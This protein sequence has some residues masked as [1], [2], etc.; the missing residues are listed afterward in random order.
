VS[1]LTATNDKPKKKKKSKHADAE[2][3]A[4]TNATAAPMEVDNAASTSTSNPT[5][6]ADKKEKKDKK[7]KKRK[8]DALMDVDGEGELPES[9]DAALAAAPLASSSAEAVTTED[10]DLPAKK[11]KK[12]SKKPKKTLDNRDSA[13][14]PAP[15]TSTSKAPITAAAT[16]TPSTSADNSAYLTTHRITLSDPSAQPFTSFP[17]LYTSPHLPGPLLPV[18]KA[19]FGT[20]AAPTPI[21][22]CAWP[23]ALQGRDVVGIAET[24]SGKTLAFGVPALA[25]LLSSG[26]S[27]TDAEH[28]DDDAQGQKRKNNKNKSPAGSGVGVLVLAPT[29][30]LAIQ[31][32]DTLTHACSILSNTPSTPAITSVAVFGGVDKTSQVRSL[33]A[34]SAQIVVGT[35]G[36]IQDLVNDG[37]L[38]L[39]GVK[40]LVLDEAD[41]M[42][43][44][45]FENDIRR[46]ISCTKEEGRQ[47]LMCG[48]LFVMLP[49]DAET[50][51]HSW[52]IYAVSATWPESV[53]RLADTFQRD[54][55]RITVGTKD[56]SA[57]T[58][59]T[60]VV[61][62]FDDPWEKD[63]R[64][65]AH[66]KRLKHPKTP[67]IHAS[68][69]EGADTTRMIVFVLYKNEAP[70]VEGVLRREGY[71]VMGLQ[72]DMSQSGRM[73]ALKAFKEGRTNTL[74]ATDVAARGLDIPNVST[75]FNYTFPLTIEDYVHR[76]GRT[77][78][79]GRT[80]TSITFFT[81]EKHEKALAGELSRLLQDGGFEDQCEE[82]KKRFPMTIRKKEHA[83]YGA[84][85]KEG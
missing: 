78:R 19:I 38:D 28:G 14:A 36:R 52:F 66:L 1:S 33:R 80:G 21:Q 77:G 42:L 34:A 47:T 85:F 15:S 17:S 43:D 67:K 27:G 39:S 79:G 48:C 7:K 6:D 60:Q 62:V 2:P 46:I 40:F 12:E 35:P 41:R 54:P 74:V 4:G 73:E 26:S 84:F 49:I 63:R 68:G 29:R 23:P 16:T 69:A 24:G 44:K 25:M 50:D 5:A 59:I 37:S 8:A 20:F 30:E 3:N 76:I 70:R 64:L 32:H 31:T 22:A 82:L 56:L 81:G 11:K 13:I 61:E 51:M 53:R 45:G 58:R 9:T 57:N 18:L 83:V 75:V 65:L 71:S 10:G 72:G 55:V